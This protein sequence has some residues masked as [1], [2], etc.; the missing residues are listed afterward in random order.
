MGVKALTEIIAKN[1]QTQYSG[2]WINFQKKNK[3]QLIQ[4]TSVSICLT[5]ILSVNSR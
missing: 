3:C 1:K 5:L 4:Q 2:I